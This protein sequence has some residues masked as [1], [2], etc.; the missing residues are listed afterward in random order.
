MRTG[1]DPERR[2]WV[3]IA[4]HG[5]GLAR[6]RAST[7]T[8]LS[9]PILLDKALGPTPPWVRPT[10]EIDVMQDLR[11]GISD[12]PSP[13]LLG[14]DW[15]GRSARVVHDVVG[16][17]RTLPNPCAKGGEIRPAIAGRGSGRVD[18]ESAKSG[19]E[20]GS[21]RRWPPRVQRTHRVTARARRLGSAT[22]GGMY[23]RG[24]PA[25]ILPM[26]RS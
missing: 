12:R 21:G 25:A 2:S 15:R 20:N 16:A 5:A 9:K 22:R 24:C 10:A 17:S 14:P 8:R 6:R 19:H 26:V 23:R 3:G 11:E 4:T 13:E 7:K 18:L 1:P